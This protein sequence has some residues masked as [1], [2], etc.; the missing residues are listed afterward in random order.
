MGTNTVMFGWKRSLPGREQLSAAHF[1]DFVG[2]LS[3]LQK[4]GRIA[5]FEPV[6]LDPN[7]SGLNGFFLIR[8]DDGKLSELL[9]S[10]AWFG[11]VVRAMMHL[12]E[13]TVV[14]GV[15]GPLVN[16]R[17]NVWVGQIPH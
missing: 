11:H 10:E 14:R 6:L 8:A 1:Q 12:D 17:M 2:Y 7:G 9:S 16:E 4:D 15:S 13:A 3:G 5:S